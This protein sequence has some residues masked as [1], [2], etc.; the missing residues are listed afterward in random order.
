MQESIPHLVI[1][2]LKKQQQIIR[3]P[4]IDKH[5]EGEGREEEEG[6]ILY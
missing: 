6:Q 1:R 4:I 5:E 3:F 2:I